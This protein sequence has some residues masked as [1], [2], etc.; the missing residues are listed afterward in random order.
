MV[1][2]DLDLCDFLIH[3]S[4]LSLDVRRPLVPDIATENDEAL[5]ICIYVLHVRSL[6]PCLFKNYTA[7]TYLANSIL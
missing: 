3:V 2:C 5:Y 4:V 1:D 6:S 7:I